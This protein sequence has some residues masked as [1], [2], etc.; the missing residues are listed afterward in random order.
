MSYFHFPFIRMVKKLQIFINSATMLQ[1]LGLVWWGVNGWSGFQFPMWIKPGRKWPMESLTKD[2]VKIFSVPRYIIGFDLYI[3]KGIF[4]ES[5]TRNMAIQ[6]KP[7]TLKTVMGIR[8]TDSYPYFL[9]TWF[10]VH[11]YKR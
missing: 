5:L 6:W 4:I 2:L 9:R 7:K 1:C 3:F 11:F 8:K 10:Y